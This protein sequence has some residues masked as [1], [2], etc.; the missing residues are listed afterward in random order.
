MKR[1]Y[2][3]QDVCKL[4]GLKFWQIYHLIYAGKWEPAR[5]VGRTLMYDDDDLAWL[6]RHFGIV[7]LPGMS[8]GGSVED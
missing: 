2:G 7:S 6:M 8:S 5:K 3:T 4:T 1:W